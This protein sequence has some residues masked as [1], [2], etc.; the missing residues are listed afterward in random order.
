MLQR[1]MFSVAPP[2]EIPDNQRNHLIIGDL[3][4]TRLNM[5]HSFNRVGNAPRFVF[6]ISNTKLQIEQSRPTGH[7]VERA[8]ANRVQ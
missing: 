6:Q 1:G 7:A 2:T 5:A 8:N 3:S 4:S